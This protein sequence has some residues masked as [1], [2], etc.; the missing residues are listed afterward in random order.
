M[1]IFSALEG[2]PVHKSPQLFEGDN[3]FSF[4]EKL[5][6]KLIDHIC[7]IGER[8]L[9]LCTQQEEF[10]LETCDAGAKAASA[11]ADATLA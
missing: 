11:R 7:P 4:K 8:A 1:R 9:E 3:M 6:D 2:I 10:L 5:S